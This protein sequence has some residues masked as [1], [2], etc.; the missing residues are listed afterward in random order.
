MDITNLKKEYDFK[1]EK[2]KQRLKDF[3]EVF[4]KDN[5]EIFEELCFCILTPNASA[6]MGINAMISLKPILYTGNLQDIQ[7]AL[8]KSGYRY[9]NIRAEYILEV[10]EFIKNE[11]KFQLKEKILSFKD[12]D[13]LRDYLVNNIKGISWKES[14]HYLRNIGFKGYCIIDKHIL[15]CLTELGIL[16]SNKRPI[17]KKQYLEIEQKMKEFSSSVGI[18]VDELDLL[19]WSH[20]TGEILK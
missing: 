18:N 5:K 11:L 6:R 13:D 2:I 10:R 9:P 19:L 15:N 20:K 14:S 1:K 17:N 16:E 3:E 7:N 8:K 4:N 12:K